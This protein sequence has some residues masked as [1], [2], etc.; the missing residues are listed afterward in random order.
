MYFQSSNIKSDR[1]ESYHPQEFYFNGINH[2]NMIPSTLLWFKLILFMHWYC[3][4][5][6]REI[7]TMI[8]E[9]I[10]ILL[11]IAKYQLRSVWIIPPTEIS[12]LWDFI[13]PLM[14]QTNLDYL[15]I[16]SK[17][18]INRKHSK[19]KKTFFCFEQWKLGYACL[20]L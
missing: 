10:Q 13:H 17:W 18:S 20:F 1:F 9:L 12:C 8:I 7:Y 2:R 16:I 14:I 19:I 11:Q 3:L 6:N 15:N 4:K 5:P